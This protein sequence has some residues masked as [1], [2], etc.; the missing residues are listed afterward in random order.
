MVSTL[1]KSCWLPN[2]L[3]KS[4]KASLT[5]GFS[6]HQLSV[7]TIMITFIVSSNYNCHDVMKALSDDQYLTLRAQLPQ[8]DLNE[9]RP[10]Y[11]TFSK[12]LVTVDQL[13]LLV[14]LGFTPF[15]HKVIGLLDDT[16]QPQPPSVNVTQV[17]V[18]G[19][20]LHS[21]RSVYTLSNADDGALQV[22]LNEGW[23]IIAVVP[24]SSSQWP[25][26]ILGHDCADA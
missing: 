7:Y 18:A 15:V 9:T 6:I 8:L 21:I 12:T 23:K 11:A 22:Y 24:P 4:Y 10:T 20:P 16:P 26:Y 19:N 13:N 3:S 2:K 1:W 25:D 5:A 14:E 17:H